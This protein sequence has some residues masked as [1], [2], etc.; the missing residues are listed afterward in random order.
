GAGALLPLAPRYR[1]LS[2]GVAIA[3]I[4]ITLV[5]RLRAHSV[6]RQRVRMGDTYARIERIRAQR[7]AGRR[8]RR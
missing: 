7:T 8:N 2:I 5:A 1:L 6:S 4:A 3:L